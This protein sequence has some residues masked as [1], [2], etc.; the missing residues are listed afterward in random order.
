[1]NHTG[2]RAAAALRR[3]ADLRYRVGIVLGSGLGGLADRVEDPTFVPYDD[4]PG[5]PRMTVTSH[6]GEVVLGHIEGIAVAVLS[7]RSHYFETGDI[8]GM[9]E[10]IATLAELGC[11]TLLLTNAA[12]SLRTEVGPGEA[13]LIS[14][15]INLSGANPLFGIP[16][17]G[18]FVSLTAAYDPGLRTDIL[19]AAEREGVTLHPGVYLFLAGP[20]FETPAEIRMVTRAGADAVGMSTVPE[21]IVGRYFGMRV[22]ALSSIVNFAAGMTGADISHQE[23]QVLAPLGAAKISRVLGRFFRDMSAGGY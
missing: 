15:H 11:D 18:R 22:A 10:P 13:M 6:A 9:W 23:T 12:G 16:D 14:D 20:S 17:D 5:F 8:R 3:A 19:G 2:V 4:L 1:M 7:G 21:V